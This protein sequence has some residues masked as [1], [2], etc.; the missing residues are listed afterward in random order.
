MLTY[1][2]GLKGRCLKFQVNAV[3]YQCESVAPNTTYRSGRSGFY[4]VAKDAGALTFSGDGKGQVK[5][6]ED[7]VVQPVDLLVIFTFKGETKKS[8][9]VGACS[10]SNPLK[11]KATVH[12]KA[13]TTGEHFEAEFLSDGSPPSPL[14]P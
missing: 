3:D 5:K 6:S 10:F 8:P 7:D 4:F 14:T 13:D 9:A 1:M 12:C 2:A 11:G